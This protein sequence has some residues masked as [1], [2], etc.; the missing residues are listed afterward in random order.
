M[1]V[2]RSM[3]GLVLD[4]TVYKSFGVETDY[5]LV[6]S[7]LNLPKPTERVARK[8]SK[9]LRV[10]RLRREDVVDQ[11]IAKLEVRFARIEMNEVNDIETEWVNFKK[12]FLEVVEEC[13]G[14]CTLKNGKKKSDWWNSEIKD[15]V[16]E[17]RVRWIKWL[18]NTKNRSQM[19]RMIDKEQKQLVK[20][21]VKEAKER[22]W[23][24]FGEDLGNAGQQRN[25]V[26]WTKVK[27]IR[28]GGNSQAPG[29]ILDESDDL[30]FGK[31]NVLKRW[32][33][34]FDELLNVEN[35]VSNE[36]VDVNSNV[37]IS[38]ISMDEIE[39]VLRKLKW[40]KAAGVDEIRNEFLLCSGNVGVRWLHRIF[41]LA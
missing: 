32:K 29:T 7:R 18:Q 14:M 26:F 37:E 25:K 1:I 17:K 28:N 22:V 30:I 12:A 19:K 15:A 2:E 36:S 38:E 3:K 21:L 4:T 8:P 23:V 24:K 11:F 6:A 13:L 9:R 41:N 16:K 35:N 34:Y 39:A 27:R 31:K 5:H 33:E 10:V 40:G 20:S